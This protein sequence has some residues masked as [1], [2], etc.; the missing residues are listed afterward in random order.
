MRNE[1]YLVA[2]C[3]IERAWTGMGMFQMLNRFWRKVEV[4]RV[5]ERIAFCFDFVI[6]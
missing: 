2:I 3:L 1:H 5:G 4:M 6:P